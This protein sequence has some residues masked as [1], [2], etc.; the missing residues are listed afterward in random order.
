[1]LMSIL[2]QNIRFKCI[3]YRIYRIYYITLLKPTGWLF[4]K[5][6]FITGKNYFENNYTYKALNN[7]FIL[8]E[9]YGPLHRMIF[10]T[11]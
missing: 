3:I 11:R 5:Y 10:K 9:L 7:L 6:W 4:K 2:N 1:M 8:K